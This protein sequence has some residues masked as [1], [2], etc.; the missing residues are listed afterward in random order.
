MKMTEGV[1]QKVWTEEGELKREDR[2]W[3]VFEGILDQ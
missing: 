3:E 2:E 1:D